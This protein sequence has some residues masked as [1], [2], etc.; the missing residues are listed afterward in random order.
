MEKQLYFNWSSGKDSALALHQLLISGEYHV[1]QLLVSMNAHYNRVTMHG[2]QRALLEKQL[3]TIAIPASTVELPQ[4]PTHE[5]YEQLMSAT[6]GQMKL[7]GYDYAG[8]GDIFLE[9]LRQY[10]E[11]QLA[12]IGIQS[13]FPLWGKNTRQLMNSF[14]EMGFKA[15]T[16]CVDDTL[17]GA[18]FLGRELDVDFLNELPAGVDPCGENGEFHTFCYY[19]PF[20]SSSVQFEKGEQ[21]LE[22]Y[23][24]NGQQSAFRFLDLLPL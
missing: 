5:Q 1:G 18:N 17:L 8:F 12:T 2:V 16:V 9:D 10:R 14:I 6:A 21:K 7:K 20:F 3:Q 4:Q 24:Y 23:Q 22:T 11:Q 15:I 19:A 13:V